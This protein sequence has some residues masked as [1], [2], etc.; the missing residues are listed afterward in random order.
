MEL[1]AGVMD[2]ESVGGR[3][4][5]SGASAGIGPVSWDTLRRSDVELGSLYGMRFRARLSLWV[6]AIRSY[7]HVICDQPSA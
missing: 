4:M 6:H 1:A 2:E 7:L 5:E 3:S